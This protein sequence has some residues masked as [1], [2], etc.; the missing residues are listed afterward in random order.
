M[1]QSSGW[2][3]EHGGSIISLL[4]AIGSAFVAG[5]FSFFAGRGTVQAQIQTALNQAFE[6]IVTE[7]RASAAHDKAYI[8]ELEAKLRGLEQY[9]LSLTELLRRHGIPIPRNP[10]TTPIFVLDSLPAPDDNIHEP[11]EK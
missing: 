1:T 2:F 4:A 7:R 9:Q 10:V 8:A 5:F 6:A 3:H 11:D